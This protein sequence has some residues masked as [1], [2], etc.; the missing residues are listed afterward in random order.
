MKQSNSASGRYVCA[1]LGVAFLV[2]A[3]GA[4]SER[5]TLRAMAGPGNAEALQAAIDCRFDD[6]LRLAEGE[7]DAE[8]STYQ[9]FSRYVQSAVYTERGEPA[10][11][12]ALIDEATADPRMNPDGASTR[13]DMQE[14]ADGVLAAIRAQRAEEIG[15]RSCPA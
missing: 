9:L 1:A 8:T 4:S 3:C 2:S 15:Q 12:A 6:A 11:A 5:F 14:A 10:R 7:A 13:E